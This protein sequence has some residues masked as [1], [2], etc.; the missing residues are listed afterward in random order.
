MENNANEL[1]NGLLVYI[2]IRMRG[3]A[4]EKIRVKVNGTELEVIQYPNKGESIIFYIFQEGIW[5]NGMELY[6]IL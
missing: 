4:M 6:H 5:H 2:N 3:E 1:Y